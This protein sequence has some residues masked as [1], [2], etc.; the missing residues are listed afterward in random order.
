MSEYFPLKTPGHRLYP[1]GLEIR[2][3]GKDEVVSY[4]RVRR[5]GSELALRNLVGGTLKGISVDDFYDP[6]LLFVMLWHRVNSFMNYPMNL[7]WECPACEAKNT[8]ELDITKLVSK[9][10]LDDYDPS[11]M[12]LDMPCGL[13]LT[14][15]LAKVGDEARARK[16][17]STLSI[18]SVTD[19]VVRKGEIVQM[20]EF[21]ENYNSYEKWE[22]V[23]KI[24][25]VEDIFTIEGFKQEFSYGPNTVMTCNCKKCEAQQNVGFRFSVLEFLPN[26]YDGSTIR[27]RILSTRPTR[28]AAKRAK[29]SLI[30]K[31]NMDPSK[32]PEKAGG[33]R[34]GEQGD[35]SEPRIPQKATQGSSSNVQ[36]LAAKLMEQAVSE[37]MEER[38]AENEMKPA[39]A[40]VK[41]G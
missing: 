41:R 39:S 21:D 12:T 27:A 13:A 10:V 38:A 32:T 2:P 4:D 34:K 20:M 15:R 29:D 40:V 31:I 19:D 35:N 5:S 8:D 9:E 22:I 24:F 36:P 25:G 23:N 28:D 6:D 33:S 11:G 3:F 1:D 7:P 30:P 17:L 18:P 37:V 26:N 16:M 14:F